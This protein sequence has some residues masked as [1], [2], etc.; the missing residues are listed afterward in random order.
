MVWC[1]AFL[2]SD[3]LTTC[4]FQ[5]SN[6]KPHSTNGYEALLFPRDQIFFIK[7]S[8]QKILGAPTQ[9]VLNIFG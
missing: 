3:F 1:N 4:G 8:I 2:S 9:S 7:K 5:L 6:T